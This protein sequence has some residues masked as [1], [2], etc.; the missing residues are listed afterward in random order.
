[1]SRHRELT[2]AKNAVL[3]AV[4]LLSDAIRAG[5]TSDEPSHL[6]FLVGSVHVAYREYR[7][8]ADALDGKGAAS[9][10]QT[11]V[12]AAHDNLPGKG[13]LRRVVVDT[14]VAHWQEY[15]VGMTC[16]QL[17]ARLRRKH[18]SVSSA[19][20][21]AENSGWIGDSGEQRVTTS[22]SK[23]IVYRPTD[24]AIERVRSYQL[25]TEER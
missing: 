21:F 10:R 8:I 12:A 2:N 20:N 6:P 9:G 7:E 16:D 14:L 5:S 24:R 19:V 15:G 23:A 22:G 25:G 18:Q 1:M 13:S 17:E 4:R 11:S 3:E